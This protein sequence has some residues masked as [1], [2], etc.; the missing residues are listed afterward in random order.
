MGDTLSPVA[1][2]DWEAFWELAKLVKTGDDIKNRLNK[3]EL[4]K[5]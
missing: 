1:E 5:R 2:E 3:D 4:V